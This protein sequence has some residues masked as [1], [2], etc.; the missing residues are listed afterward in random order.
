MVHV[1]IWY[2]NCLRSSL[3]LCHGNHRCAPDTPGQRTDFTPPRLRHALPTDQYQRPFRKGDP[4]VTP[5]RKAVDLVRDCLA[6]DEGKDADPEIRRT[7][8]SRPGLA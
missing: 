2:T 7:F 6:A 4:G 3:R 5:V 1:E 8:F